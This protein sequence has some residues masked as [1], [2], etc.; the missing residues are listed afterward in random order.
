MESRVGSHETMSEPSH[1][2]ADSDPIVVSSPSEGISLVTLNRPDRLNSMDRGMVTGGLRETFESIDAN[3]SNRVMIISGNGRAFCAGGDLDSDSFKLSK[4]E[5]TSYIRAA[6]RTVV[7]LRSMAIPT[8]AAVN[9]P[10][11]GGGCGLALACDLR[12]ASQSASFSVPFAKMGLVPDFGVSYLLPRL[13][14]AGRALEFALSGR[15]VESNEALRI[16]LVDRIADNVLATAIDLAMTLMVA[17]PSAAAATK[18]LLYAASDSAFEHHVL[19]LETLSQVE[20][21]SGAAFA[22]RFAQ[23]RRSIGA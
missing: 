7:A 21:M 4:E 14:G 6:Q 23:Y 3:P 17:A 13:I 22:E 20:A 5:S 1:P 16:G 11:A 12:V 2:K 19:E 8:I 9:G 18:D 10:A 15:K